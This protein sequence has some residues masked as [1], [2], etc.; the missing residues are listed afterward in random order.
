MKRTA[1][2]SVLTLSVIMLLFSCGVTTRNKN[3]GLFSLTL[4]TT[5]AGEFSL[6]QIRSNKVSV[7]VFLSPGC[8]MCQDYTLT[9]NELYEKYKLR[10][11]EVYAV[12]LGKKVTSDEIDNY[13]KTYSV[14]FNMLID[15]K[16]QLAGMLDAKVTPEV[17]VIDGMGEEIYKG[18][19]DNWFDEQGEKRSS[20]TE[21]YLNDALQA[22]LTGT[23]A[24]VTAV[25]AK[26][27]PIE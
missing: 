8:T 27:C 22:A 10:G 5:N 21:H 17:F 15:D 14:K 19:I 26:G 7:F 18:A 9:L 23:K 13:A 16:K 3:E 6:K 1:T 20:I 11:V 12:F 25:E 4:K 2:R 24:K